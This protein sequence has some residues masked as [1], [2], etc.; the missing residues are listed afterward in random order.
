MALTGLK[1]KIAYP[2]QGRNLPLLVLMHAWASLTIDDLI[3]DRFVQLGFFVIAPGMR[4]R[5]GAQGT[6]DASG[7]E[8]YD[9]LDA[10]KYIQTNY[11]DRINDKVS[12]CG[13]SGGG[14]NAMA[15]ACK[16]PDTFNCCISNFGM[17]DYGYDATYGWYAQNANYWSDLISY[18]GGDPTQVPNNYHS[19]DAIYG[20]INYTGGKMVL[21]GDTEDT[22]VPHNQSTR[23]KDAMVAA[24]MSNY[25]ELYSTTSDSIRYLHTMTYDGIPERQ[26]EATW[27]PLA[28][29]TA[30]WTIS[31]SGTINVMGF[32]HTKRFEIWLG[33]GLTAAASCAYDTVTGTYTFNA[34]TTANTAVSITQ[35]TKTASGTLV[36][37]TPLT[38]TVA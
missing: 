22:T 10:I 35:G 13:W 2:K 34:L 5:D 29:N 3:I 9:I 19:R 27:M 11:A 12:I 1:L 4:G 26:A 18:I 32:I 28:K 37:G 38:L 36:P 6:H 16:L 7:R 14:G 23:L 25:T 21:V 30:A 17:S 33:T 24:G 15:C 20:I 31:A 8:I